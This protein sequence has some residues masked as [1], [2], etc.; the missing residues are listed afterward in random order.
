MNT[1][2]LVG[3]G[4]VLGALARFAVGSQLSGRRQATLAV[5]VLGSFALGAL[6]AGLADGAALL[7]MF[8]TGFCGAFTTFSSF[9]VETV[10]L[11]E[12]G[13]RREAVRNAT[14]NLAGALAAVGL[15]GL[16]AALFW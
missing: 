15:G 14:L 5:N 11:Y 3:A 4:G 6:V 8:G 13:A 9:A 7:T 2:L 16:S 10:E 1:F 12:T